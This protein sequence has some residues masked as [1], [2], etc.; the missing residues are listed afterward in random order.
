MATVSSKM[1]RPPIAQK[2]VFEAIH[3]RIIHGDLAPSSR[4]PTRR[5]IGE[6][7][8]VGLPAVQR[9]LEQLIDDGFVV[10]RG[11]QGT[12][13]S[14]KPPHLSRYC[15]VFEDPLSMSRVVPTPRFW[16]ALSQGAD[17]LS[18]KIKCP[19][20]IF[21]GVWGPENVT[22]YRRLSSDV[23]RHR[24]AG[25]FFPN[26][27]IHINKSS[28]VTEPGLPRVVVMTS[29]EELPMHRMLLDIES[30]YDRGLAE[31]KRQG[32]KRIRADFRRFPAISAP[33]YPLIH[34]I[35]VCTYKMFDTGGIKTKSSM[36]V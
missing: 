11:T 17:R 27:P 2:Q 26:P 33:M 35:Y 18:R 7:F 23:R 19:I 15:L 21:D 10:P 6:E 3:R 12:F 9:A 30:F 32:C 36:R 29:Q 14:D 25:L 5:E 4:L 16:T 13:V 8:K 22:N 28:I 34:H 31:L 1:G 24:L 20:E